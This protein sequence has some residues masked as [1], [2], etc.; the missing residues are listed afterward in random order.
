VEVGIVEAAVVEAVVEGVFGRIA[1]A[2]WFS[3]NKG[4]TY[5]EKPT[6]W[7]VPS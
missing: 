3:Q 5:A 6:A 7:K 4:I 2:S 1:Q